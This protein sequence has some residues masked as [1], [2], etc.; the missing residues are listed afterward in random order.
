LCSLAREHWAPGIPRIAR[1]LER[2]R[3]RLISFVLPMPDI[4]ARYDAMFPADRTHRSLQSWAMFE[5]REPTA[6][7]SQYIFWCRSDAFWL[8]SG[9]VAR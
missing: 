4:R 3:L 6:F 2:L 7:I 5:R 9:G 1:A 8:Q